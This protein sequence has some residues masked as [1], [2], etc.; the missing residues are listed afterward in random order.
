MSKATP[1]MLFGLK[2]GVLTM[3]HEVTMQL[4]IVSTLY[5]LTTV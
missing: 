4:V 1:G 2:T 3:E 5:T